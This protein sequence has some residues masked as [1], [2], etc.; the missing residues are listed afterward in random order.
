MK[1][2]IIEGGGGLEVLKFKEV[3]DFIVGEGEV[4]IKVV[5]VVFNWVDVM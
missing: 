5:V 1:V 3:D 2:I 4:L